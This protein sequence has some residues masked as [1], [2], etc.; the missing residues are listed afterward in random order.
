M[1][2]GHTRQSIFPGGVHSQAEQNAAP[3]VKASQQGD[4]EAFA[5]L[6]RR[7]QRRIFNLSLGLLQDEE[8]ASECTQEA[9]VVAWQGLPGFRGGE[10][11]FP[12]WLYRLAYQCGLRQLA[13]R[14]REQAQHS[15]GEAKQVLVGRHPEKQGAETTRRQGLQALVREH[16]ESLPLQDRTVLVL[17]HLHDQTYEEIAA[18]L[19]V[20]IGTVKTRLLRA[21]TLLAE[22]LAGTAPL[23]PRATM[24]RTPLTENEE[25]M[26]PSGQF[27]FHGRKQ[28]DIPDHPETDDFAQHQHAWREQQLGWVEQQH[29][30]LAQQEAWLEQ[31]RGWVEQQQ[32]WLEQRRGWLVEQRRWIEQRR[33]WMTPQGDRL[34]QHAAWLTQQEAW[35]D[36]QH[37]ALVQQY[38]EVVQHHH[39]VQQR[40]SWLDRKPRL[41]T[42]RDGASIQADEAGERQSG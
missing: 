11:D 35:L 21:R 32:G 4:Q 22:R 20:S 41:L 39:W 13:R 29:S 3:L 42:Q 16:L 8:D 40:R 25:V 5:F 34:T 17:R 38:S 15:A 30:A 9:F 26:H 19:S 6:V 14:T 2:A 37:T 31:R 7:H 1:H 27:R 28:D 10:A 33:G 12:T 24:V 23:V 18:I 36:Q